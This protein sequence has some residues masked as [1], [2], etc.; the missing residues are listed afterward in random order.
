MPCAVDGSSCISPIAPDD[1]FALALNF[2]SASIT[3]ASSAGSMVVA[4]MTA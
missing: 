2:D 3:A 1:D 4:R